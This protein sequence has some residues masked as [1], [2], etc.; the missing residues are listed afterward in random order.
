MANPTLSNLPDRQ[1]LED[2]Y[3]ENQSIYV[4]ELHRITKHLKKMLFTN[5]INA[6][7]KSRVKAFD[8]YFNKLLRLMNNATEDKVLLTD[9]LAVRIICPFLE[10]RDQLIKLLT[11][12]FNVTEIESKGEKRSF[13]E[14]G[15]D[16]THLLADL[17]PE[18]KAT[19]IPFTTPVFEIQLRTILQEAWAEV[20]HELIYKANFSLL[21]TSIRRKL[22][23]LN[24]SL[25]LSDIIFQEIRD[26]QKE[27]QKLDEQRRKKL[28]DKVK[29]IDKLSLIDK[30]MPK[31]ELEKD[32]KEEFTVLPQKELDKLILEALDAHSNQQYTKAINIY[33]SI[34][35]SEL[36]TKISSIIYNHRGMAYFVQSE[37]ELS[38]KDFTQALND[39][40]ENYRALNNRALSYKMQKKFDQALTDFESSIEIS[41]TQ[42]DAY[43]GCALIYYDLDN[44]TDAINF[45]NKALNINPDF[46]AARELKSI[47]SAKIF[48]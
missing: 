36:D 41:Q 40:S 32:L 34:L 24:A 5:G 37:Y 48:K 22:A 42:T 38:I 29:E 43:Y 8:S 15:Y 10:D 11:K 44:Y 13:N 12:E 19:K 30:I 27:I 17:P 33:T 3:D 2:I 9:V 18:S 28:Q 7:I 25:A 16:S 45:C 26:Y 31:E 46:T 4:I 1:R 35:E 14:F 21:N 39:N 6:T 20:E 23:S 47:I